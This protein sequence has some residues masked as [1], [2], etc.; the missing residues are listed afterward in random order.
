VTEHTNKKSKVLNTIFSKNW[1]QSQNSWHRDNDIK[2]FQPE[3][4]QI[5][6]AIVQTLVA[7]ATGTRDLCTPA[8]NRRVQKTFQIAEV[9]KAVLDGFIHGILDDF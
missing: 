9:A 7:L 5:L 2:K 3:G 1:G 4:S 8:I 6:A